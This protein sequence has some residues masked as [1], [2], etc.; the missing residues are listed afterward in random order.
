MP[1]TLPLNQHLLHFLL[2]LDNLHLSNV[3]DIYLP[4]CFNLSFPC[5]KQNKNKASHKFSQNTKI[6][7]K[8]NEKN[9]NKTIHTSEECFFFI[10]R[11][12]ENILGVMKKKS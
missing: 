5:A 10:F 6:F 11:I 1:R 8:M 12:F 7:S 9:K 3:S 4:S 2:V